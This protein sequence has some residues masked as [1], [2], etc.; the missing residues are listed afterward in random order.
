MM[1]HRETCSEEPIVDAAK[2]EFRQLL[3]EALAL[4]DRTGLPPEIGARLQEV[5]DLVEGCGDA[6]SLRK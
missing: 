1:S 5:I 6:G 2:D 3:N 4:A